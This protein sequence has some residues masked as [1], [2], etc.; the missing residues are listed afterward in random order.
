MTVWTES[1][2]TTAGRMAVSL[3]LLSTFALALASY[4]GIL[5]DTHEINLKRKGSLCETLAV[6]CSL[7]AQRGDTSGV[8]ESLRAFVDRN[9]DVLSACLRDSNDHVIAEFGDHQE[10]WRLER[11]AKSTQDNIYVPITGNGKRW[12]TVEVSFT[13]QQGMWKSILGHPVVSVSIVCICVNIILFR[14]FMGRLLR[15][16][17]PSTSVPAHVRTTLDTFA[18][19]VVVLDNDQ[20]IVLANKSFMQYVGKPVSDLLGSSVDDLPW[21]FEADST[22]PPWTP[23]SGDAPRTGERLT[24]TTGTSE[25][26]TFLVNASPIIADDGAR[27]GTIASFDDITQMERKK[28]ELSTML[29]DLQTSREELTRRNQEL[30]FLATRDSLTGCMNRRTF[31]ES[32]DHL[33]QNSRRAQTP[34][35]CIMVDVDHFKSVNDNHGHS[36]GDEVLKKVA[37]TIS[38]TVRGR[39]IVCRYG[40]EEFCVLLP[41]ADL[42]GACEIAERVR[43]AVAEIPFDELSVTASLGVSDMSLGAKNPQEMLDQAD[44]CLYVAKRGGRNRVVRWDNVPDVV[45]V[46]SQ[47]N[48][49]DNRDASS[50]SDSDL[51]LP[52]PAVASLLSALAYRDP[53]TAAHC[54]RVAELSVATARGLMAVKDAYFLEIAALLH[55]IGKIGVPDAILLKPGPLTKDEWEIM[56]MHDRIGVE[57]VEASFSQKQ[58]V[59]IVRYHH[60]TFKASPHLPHLPAGTDIPLGAR[61]VTIADAYDAMV[62]DRVYRKGRTPEAAFQE[63]RR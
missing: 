6:N 29:V 38:S 12:G 42:T 61:I 47:R 40:G 54:T 11:G 7:L 46:R 17:D 49:C 33:W 52:Y 41:H 48:E 10:F 44:K 16:L 1:Q 51:T 45:E 22:E 39:D 30:H 14:L 63:L 26:R 25:R 56:Q 27:R 18:E 34:L 57:I 13:A 4:I 50:D 37:H 8:S 31:F 59:D 60:A 24:L 2:I 5:P 23:I 43:I 36:M 21:Q 20:R 28:S 62:S 32:F 35:S 58:M 15:Y 9:D 19:G 53:D 3:S 55:D